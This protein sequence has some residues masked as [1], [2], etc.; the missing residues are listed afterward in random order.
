MSLSAV[1][2]KIEI[3]KLI[4]SGLI[5]NINNF[6][7]LPNDTHRYKYNPLKELSN[8]L[9]IN[10][11][12]YYIVS[13]SKRLNKKTTII[14]D[15]SK[16]SEKNEYVRKLI[17]QLRKINTGDLD[18]TSIDFGKIPIKQ[19]RKLILQNID[20]QKLAIISDNGQ[21][22]FL[23]DKVVND[24]MKNKMKDSDLPNQTQDDDNYDETSA[25]LSK[26]KSITL[27]LIKDVKTK[28]GG[29]FFK[30]LNNTHI[31]LKRYNIFNDTDTLE[32]NDNCLYIALEAGGLGND[33]LELLKSFVNNRV[34][35]KCKLKDVC[36]KLEIM[37]K[38]TSI[39]KDLTSRVEKYGDTIY[40]EDLY[41][42]GLVDEH[43]FIVDRTEVTTYCIEHYDEV[44]DIPNCNNIISKNSNGTYNKSNT[45]FIQ[46]YKLIKLLLSNK[47]T[48]LKPI[49]YDDNIMNTQFYDK[50]TE[51]KT[52]EYPHT[53]VKYQ[54]YKPK[55]KQHFYKVFFD[56][57][58]ETTKTHKPYLVRYETEDNEIREFIGE[59]CAID[60]LNNLP[61][62]LNI[63]LIAHNAN[64]DC[65]FLLKYLSHEKPL[66]K[67][68]RI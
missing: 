37:I 2:A 63:M 10:F 24:I 4:V 12:L 55:E 6:I 41:H 9:L 25:V 26:T 36:N 22:Y 11:S 51:Y 48:L 3:N 29:G 16:R 30:Y 64:Y 44:K 39:N 1:Q 46:S 5:V 28:P 13:M 40:C 31:D 19:A 53:C 20:K 54:A 21:T 60:M 43:Y 61:D 56:F 15:K 52:L 57:E 68:G 38:L 33:K 18:E 45:E 67:G 42:I 49:V 58:T 47:E 34:V 8:R 32:Y 65:R 14:E 66:V 23:N 7:T 59:N 17:E 50:V 27:K 35:P 62:K